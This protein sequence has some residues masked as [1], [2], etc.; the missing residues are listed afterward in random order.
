MILSLPKISNAEINQCCNIPKRPTILSNRWQEDWSVLANPNVPREP[1]DALKYIPL[2]MTDSKTYLSFGANLRNRYEYINAINFGVMP[3]PNNHAQSYLI[4]RMEAHADLHIANQL[5]VYVQ[6][7]NDEAPGKT[8]IFPVD[9]DRLDLEQ[10]FILLTEPVGTGTLRFRAGRQQMAFDL[11][12]FISLRDG[13]NVRQSFDA[14]WSDYTIEKWKFIAFYSRPVES[15]NLRCFDDHSINAFTFS[16]FRIQRTFTDYAN[17]SFYIGHFKQDN[18]F[19][20]SVVGNERRNLFDIRFVGGDG[21]SY[22]WDLETMGQIGNIANKKIRAWACGSVSG[23]TFQNVYLKPRIGFQFDAGSGTQNQNSH[24][25]N[26][27]N[28]LFPNGV[29]FNLANYTSYA[30]LIHIKPSL[31]LTPNPCWSA[32]FA[33]AGQWRESTADAVYVEPHS[34]I[35]R[36][37]G[38]PGKYT[39]TYYQTNVSWQMTPHIENALQVVYFNV[40]DAIRRVGGHNSTYVGVESKIGW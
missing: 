10:A 33:V 29:Y 39:G 30:N 24:I 18:V 32:M 14:L 27:F 21:T 20:P 5:Q 13:P 7:Q 1:L 40:A 8:I 4:S 22:D 34:P 15:L 3:P 38:V 23:Y 35:P 2:S 28:P 19:Y 6:L 16:L 31:T 9:E 12:R 17:V 11:Q 37:A 26:T 36:T 25:L